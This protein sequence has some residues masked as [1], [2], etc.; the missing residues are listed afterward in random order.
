[1][2]EHRVWQQYILE[3]AEDIVD[4][5]GATGGTIVDIAERKDIGVHNRGHQRDVRA[6]SYSIL[7]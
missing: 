4:T 5:P 6:V 2:E 7:R 3:A 1:M